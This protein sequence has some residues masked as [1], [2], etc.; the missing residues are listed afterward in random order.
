[1]V[2][3]KIRAVTRQVE[4]ANPLWGATNP[5]M[6]FII[7]YSGVGLYPGHGIVLCIGTLATMT[8]RVAGEAH[9]E[10]GT[11]NSLRTLAR[12]IEMA[13]RNSEIPCSAFV[14][15]NALNIVSNELLIWD[16]LDVH[17]DMLGALGLSPYYSEDI[18]S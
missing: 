15:N 13:C 16:N 1:M 17:M 9:P 2:E 4:L 6:P 5:D 3:G 12:C 10:E 11:F 14:K 7:H 18:S 8:F